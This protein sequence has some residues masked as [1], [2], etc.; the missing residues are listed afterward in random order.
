M[1]LIVRMF[2]SAMHVLT[3]APGMQGFNGQQ[4]QLAHMLHLADYAT[5]HLRV[6]VMI[7][8]GKRR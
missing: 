5:L 4:L 3:S 7:I 8:G 2:T 6:A 1:N